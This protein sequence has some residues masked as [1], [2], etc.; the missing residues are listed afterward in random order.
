MVTRVEHA[1][2]RIEFTFPNGTAWTGNLSATAN[3]GLAEDLAYGLV[4][5]VHPLGRITAAQ[6]AMAY[7]STIRRM[8]AELV[9]MGF[10]G[11]LSDLRTSHVLSY[12]M[13]VGGRR[14]FHTRRLLAG[15][16]DRVDAGIRVHLQGKAVK[17]PPRSKPLQPYTD[18]EWRQIEA[19][20]RDY[21][22]QVMARQ[23]EV[24][25]LA[26]LGPDSSDLGRNRQNFAWL[27]REHGP[28]KV[29]DATRVL[30][31]TVDYFRD[32]IGGQFRAVRNAMFPKVDAVVAMR[33]LFGVYSGVVPDGIRDLGVDDFTWTGN[34]TVLMDY[35]KGRRGPES[36]NLPTRAVRL[37]ER[38]LEMSEPLRRFAPES[39][40]GDLFIF[41]NG[42]NGR[43]A[44]GTSQLAVLSTRMAPKSGNT[45]RRQLA[46]DLQLRTDAGTPL[47]LHS[48]RIRTTYH[49]VL[50]RRG[51]TG[52]TKIDPNHTAAV[53]GS[54]YVSTTTPA[55]AEA[56]ESIIEDAQAD[57]LRR[58]R[59]PIVLDDEEAAKF[60]TRQ[61]E[62]AHRLGLDAE[63]M[64][65]LLGGE[66]D[67][68]TAACTNQLAGLHGPAGKPCPARPW[69]CLLCPLAVFTP[70]HAPNLLRLKA[71]FARQSRQMTVQ[72][73]LAVF[74]PYAD[75][76]DHDI[77]PRFDSR[78]LEAA[79]G[80]VADVDAELP[81]RPEEGTQ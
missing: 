52:R 31:L 14:V 38:W 36:V 2:L 71:Y 50:A 53:E 39:V 30:G 58:S 55:Q 7:T 16:G 17:S 27:V 15:C 72:Q 76:L 74:G 12:W 4:Q 24:L 64:V 75:R 51:W 47:L 22:Q 40:A 65:E 67:V 41:L 81:L 35:V 5:M 20:L 60:V 73:F 32:G 11:R 9:A 28:L 6:S 57:I 80:E 34:R 25:D 59:P 66:M 26:A 43:E 42:D 77:L 19:G 3:E 46:R 13:S 56:I 29:R 21:L 18:G 79:A 78:Q 68:F 63:A 49:N 44:H 70:R 69:V 54:H 1:P 48:A 33:L 45:A 61:P 37:L 62:Q 23:R 8:V 10:H